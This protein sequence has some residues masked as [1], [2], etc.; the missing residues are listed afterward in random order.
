MSSTIEDALP[1]DSAL[2]GDEIIERVRG[3][4]LDSYIQK[5]KLISGDEAGTEQSSRMRVEW[6]NFRDDEDH[7]TEGVISKTVIIYE[8][9]FEM[10]HTSYL[11]VNQDE[12]ANDQFVYF[13]SSRRVRRV[14]LR[15]E[16][17]F[18]TDFSFEDIVPRAAEHSTYKRLPDELVDSTPC[19]VIE[20]VPKPRANSEYSRFRLYVKKD[21]Y[22]PIRTRYWDD[23]GLEIKELRA[24]VESIRKFDG[25]WIPMEAT[26]RHLQFKSYTKLFVEHLEPNPSISAAR[27][28]VRRLEG[29]H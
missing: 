1:P 3:N 14:N 26:M 12:R 18:G 6:R 28:S 13:P 22:V 20:A 25:S 24:K 10:R 9:P 23:K 4:S 27:F 17:V 15:G 29:G 11:I 2:T 7:P 8:D 19:Y 21:Q 5:S 16:A